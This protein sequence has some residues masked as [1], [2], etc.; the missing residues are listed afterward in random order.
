MISP[1]DE[2]PSKFVSCGRF[3]KLSGVPRCGLTKVNGGVWQ[4]RFWEHFIRDNADC[5]A[6]IDYCH[7]NLLKHGY[8]KQVTDWPY[9]TFHRYVDAGVYSLDWAGG[10]EPC[11]IVGE[12]D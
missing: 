12:R 6:H 11:R 4:R 5:A 10:T 1:T 3:R 8:V 2:K 7:I 9:S